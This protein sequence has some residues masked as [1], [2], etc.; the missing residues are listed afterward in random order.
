MWQKKKLVRNAKKSKERRELGMVA[1]SPPCPRG[2]AWPWQ[3]TALPRSFPTPNP[4]FPA[5]RGV[6]GESHGNSYTERQQKSAQS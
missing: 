3:V 2:P 6:P 4:D 1:L 5:R